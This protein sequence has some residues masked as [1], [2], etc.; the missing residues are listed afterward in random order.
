MKLTAR[1]APSIVCSATPEF[2]DLQCNDMI[3]LA[4]SAGRDPRVL[5][6]EVAEVAQN[7]LFEDVSVAGPGS[8]DFRL[9]NATPWRQAP[10]LLIRRSPP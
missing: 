6:A 7:A 3:R 8:V 9:T 5:A 2:G 4:K 10:S 1:A